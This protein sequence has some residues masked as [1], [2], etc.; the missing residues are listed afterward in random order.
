MFNSQEEAAVCIDIFAKTYCA[1][2]DNPSLYN[3]VNQQSVCYE[4]AD[5]LISK[6]RKEKDTLSI[7][8]L[9]SLSTQ[10]VSLIKD[11]NKFIEVRRSSS[12]INQLISSIKQSWFINKIDTIKHVRSQTNCGLKEAKDFCEA[13]MYVD[14][15]IKGIIE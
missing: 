2:L 10:I 12:E 9:I 6:L 15:V 4:M 5:A 11:G 8:D 3:V 14:E 1:T 13:V 7:T